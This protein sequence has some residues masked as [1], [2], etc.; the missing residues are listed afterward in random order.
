MTN[1]NERE[2][3]AFANDYR[4]IL[5]D[6]VKKLSEFD[7][8]YFAQYKIQIIKNSLISP[9]KN[10][11]DFGCGDGISCEFFRK[12]FPESAITGIDV[13]SKSMKIAEN[14]K[15]PNSSFIFYDGDELPFDTNSFDLI[16]AAGVFHHIEKQ[17]HFNL[18]KE[19][20]RVLDKNGKLFIF[21]HNPFNPFTKKVVKDCIFDIGAELIFPNFFKKTFQKSNFKNVQINYTLFFPR[22]NLFKRL[23]AL[24]KHLKRCPL[25]AQYYLEA[26]KTN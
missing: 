25:G 2:F 10:I 5:K 24:E 6:S 3:D 20:N 13:S 19:L 1:D 8:E 23:F 4:D 26:M 21:E 14:K 11:L 18:A 9:P 22:Y 15:I 16:F 17:K 7:C 12:Y